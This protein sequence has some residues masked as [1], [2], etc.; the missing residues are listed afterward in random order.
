M[1]KAILI[2][3]FATIVLLFSGKARAEP[4]NGLALMA[5][6]AEHHYRLVQDTKADLIFTGTGIAFGMDFQFVV[7]DQWSINT[8]LQWSFENTTDIFNVPGNTEGT[9]FTYNA[10]FQTRYWFN[11]IYICPQIGIYYE[12][13]TSHSDQVFSQRGVGGGFAVG[14]EGKNGW[15][16]NLQYDLETA[17]PIGVDNIQIYRL[18]VGFRWK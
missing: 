11:N 12:I 5:G 1:K 6:Y 7:T 13:F 15:L 18:L 4:G 3:A 10:I 2:T 14:W 9:V 16:V 8:A 17:A